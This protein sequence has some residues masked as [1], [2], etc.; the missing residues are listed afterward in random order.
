[1]TSDETVSVPAG[2]AISLLAFVALIVIGLS[3]EG[4]DPGT[5]PDLRNGRAFIQYNLWTAGNR[6]YAVWIGHDGTP[7]TGWRAVDGDEC[8]PT[9]CRR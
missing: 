9:T 8:E 1:V 4:P 2:I 5:Q 3:D 7:Y 6:Q